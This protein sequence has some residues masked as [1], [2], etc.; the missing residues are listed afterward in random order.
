MFFNRLKRAE[1]PNVIIE[2]VKGKWMGEKAIVAVVEPQAFLEFRILFS[3]TASVSWP[4]QGG[5]TGR[6][7]SNEPN[8]S[9][10]PKALTDEKGVVIIDDVKTYGPAD[11][12]IPE[13][14]DFDLFK[15][16]PLFIVLERDGHTNKYFKRLGVSAKF[17]ALTTQNVWS[18]L[19]EKE[20]AAKRAERAK[21]IEASKNEIE[22]HLKREG[23]LFCEKC[24]GVYP[25]GTT[26]CE[27]CH[28]P[29]TPLSA[30]R[31]K[32]LVEASHTHVG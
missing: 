20:K 31:L 10:Q 4:F 17:L 13:A 14:V 5:K 24:E 9:N 22:E 15:K 1:R 19:R 2:Q 16:S 30:D 28:V 26:E 11:E 21:E 27:D 8:T 29:T 3:P 6:L 7:S 12:E 32:E 18:R 25:S 23:I